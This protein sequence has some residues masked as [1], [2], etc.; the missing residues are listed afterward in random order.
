[1]PRLMHEA[2]VRLV[3]SAPEVVVGLLRSSL[4]LD[5]PV[6][7]Q[8]RVTAAELGGART[9]AGRRNNCEGGD[10]GQPWARQPAGRALL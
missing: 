2:L 3:R 9:Q 6:N 4:G 7:L 10:A 8:P 5:V 1:M